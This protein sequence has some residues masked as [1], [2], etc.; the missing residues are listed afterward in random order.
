MIPL[1]ER[2]IIQAMWNAGSLQE[3]ET[4]LDEAS[5]RWPQ[6]YAVWLLRAEFLTHTGRADQAI[7]LL[8]DASVR[9]VGYPEDQLNAALAAARA[10][11]GAMPPAGAVSI[12]LAILEAGSP[13]DD[14]YDAKVT[15]LSEEIKHHLKEEELHCANM[16]SDCRSSSSRRS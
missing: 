13:E 4:R 11:S 16:P 2:T 9:P 12:N 3:A 6:H 5:A 14:F 1:S 8:G 15:V 7:C 10:V